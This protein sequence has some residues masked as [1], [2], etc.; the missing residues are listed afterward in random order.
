[1]AI[2]FLLSVLIKQATFYTCVYNYNSTSNVCST[3]FTRTAARV[4]G[5]CCWPRA[6]YFHKLSYMLFVHIH[7][8]GIKY[9]KLPTMQGFTYDATRTRDDNTKAR[10]VEEE[11]SLFEKEPTADSSWVGG[12]PSPG[13]REAGRLSFFFFSFFFFWRRGCRQPTSQLGHASSI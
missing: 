12:V 3:R 1:M 5:N 2:R 8:G 6:N 10:K 9:R 7:S 4:P 13:G 11:Q